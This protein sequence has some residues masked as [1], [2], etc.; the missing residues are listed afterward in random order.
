MSILV[1]WGREFP[2][3]GNIPQLLDTIINRFRPV[4]TVIRTLYHITFLF[5]DSS[6]LIIPVKFLQSLPA[7]QTLR[8]YLL[9][10]T[11][12]LPETLFHRPPPQ[13]SIVSLQIVYDLDQS[14]PFFVLFRDNF[15]YD[16]LRITPEAVLPEPET[17]LLT[18]QEGT[19]RQVSVQS[20][21]IAL[22]TETDGKFTV[23]CAK[24]H[25]LDPISGWSL[26]CE[27]DS[28]CEVDIQ[29]PCIYFWRPD[30]LF[31]CSLDQTGRRR[32]PRPLVSV[33][34]GSVV[35]VQTFGQFLAYD[36]ATRE[37]VEVYGKNKKVC[38][39]LAGE[40]EYCDM[41][42]LGNRLFA[43][44]KTEIAVFDVVSG[45]CV[46]QVG[47]PRTEQWI[48]S[49]NRSY[50]AVFIGSR[51][52]TVSKAEVGP[53]ISL[54]G[55]RGL[56]VSQ[57]KKAKEAVGTVAAPVLMMANRSPYLAAV[58]NADDIAAECRRR[59]APGTIQEFVRPTLL[60]LHDLLL[61]KPP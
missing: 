8:S 29:P 10:P 41:V 55:S 40:G 15:T 56:I 54:H 58:L 7:C 60:K 26:Q 36:N 5:K 57:L 31:G 37:I 21:L 51:A 20:G 50:G 61:N 25:L 38:T 39:T 14:D 12:P 35:R 43:V 13:F 16:V 48:I 30:G 45:E 44:G 3:S 34:G 53:Y 2:V 28:E 33:L 17:M 11:N 27:L 24:F 59:G 9:N 49:A 46:G 18:M 19:L 6:L 1:E 42:L 4:R 47:V 52:F 32:F 23:Y 22:M